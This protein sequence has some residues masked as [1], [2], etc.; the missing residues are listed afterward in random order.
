[1]STATEKNNYKVFIDDRLIAIRQATNSGNTVTIIPSNKED[2]LNVTDENRFFVAVSNIQDI[3]GN[4]I[5]YR[6]PKRYNQFREFFTQKI[7]GPNEAFEL[8]D[9]SI[10]LDSIPLDRIKP[11]FREERMEDYWKNTPFLKNGSLEN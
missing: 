2:L 7:L 8:N 4:I 5:N 3:D 9:E 6:E 11:M 10:L 1:M